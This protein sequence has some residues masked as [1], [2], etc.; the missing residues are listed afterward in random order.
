MK[1]VLFATLLSFVLIAATDPYTIKRISDKDFRYEFYTIDKDITIKHHKTYFWFKGGLIHK[2]EGGV[3]GQLLHGE[4]KKHFH[5]NQLA[6]QGTFKK[7]LKVGLWK[8]W[9]ENGST[10]ST[11]EY[12]NGQKHGNFYS[13]NIEGKMLEKGF[14]RSG[15]KQG[16]WINFVKKDTIRYKKGKVFIPKPK[17]SKEEKAIAKE[18]AKKKK[19]ALKLQKETEKT[20]KKAKKEENKKQ[21]KK[22]NAS[23]SKKE[24]KAKKDNFFTR[25][26]SKKE[27]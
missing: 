4:F 11:Q 25:L 21:T 15:K 10:E 26:F 9:F 1:N 5:S 2:A 17:L 12:S 6:E 14:Y 22:T 27:K 18:Q 19:E 23:T 16:Y 8:N 7:G 20:L 13:Y 24:D 3:S